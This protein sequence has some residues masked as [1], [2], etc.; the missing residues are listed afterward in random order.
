METPGTSGKLKID[1]PGIQKIVHIGNQKEQILNRLV[2][3]LDNQQISQKLTKKI[4]VQKSTI[5][6]S[7]PP[8]PTKHRR[9]KTSHLESKLIQK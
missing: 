7:R 3:K 1:T 9:K 2:L 5:T 4:L 8:K 6:S